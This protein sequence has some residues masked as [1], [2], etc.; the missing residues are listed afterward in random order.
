MRF[1]PR[2]VLAHWWWGQGPGHPRADYFPLVG[3]AGSWGLCL[4]GPVGPGASAGALVCGVRPWALCWT[5][6]LPGAA[7]GSGGLK[8]M[9]LL[10]GGAVFP[11]G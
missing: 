3:R 11:P 10:V 8:A 9:C 5:V 6:L 2:L 4:Q 1:L 7:V